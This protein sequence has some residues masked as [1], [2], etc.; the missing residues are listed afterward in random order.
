MIIE[1]R[2]RNYLKKSVNVDTAG[3]ITSHIPIKC[4]PFVFEYLF[5]PGRN[6]SIGCKS[7]GILGTSC[8]L[9][10]STAVI[11]EITVNIRL[12]LVIHCSSLKR[13]ANTMVHDFSN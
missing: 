13:P 2:C 5:N 9:C 6:M 8:C 1:K 11:K 12:G 4:D 7:H 3:E 10:N